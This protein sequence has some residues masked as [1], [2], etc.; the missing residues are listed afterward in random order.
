VKKSK[1]S[2]EKII[3]IL[4]EADA[5][6]GAGTKVLDLCRKQLGVPSWWM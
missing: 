1:F 3:S 5:D 2:D 4:S 6:A